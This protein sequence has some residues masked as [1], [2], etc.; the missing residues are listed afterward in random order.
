MLNKLL[1]NGETIYFDKNDK[2]KTAS[3][4]MFTF[5]PFTETHA[6]ERHILAS[7]L[8]NS[9]EIYKVEKDFNAYCQELYDVYFSFKNT[10]LGRT[11]LFNS[12]VT[13][14]NPSY[15]YTPVVFDE[16]NASSK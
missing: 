16:I 3:V 14:V 5:F 12:I 2:F 6:S 4:S 9:N 10:R 7:I 1:I 15:V 8:S 13:F 11:G